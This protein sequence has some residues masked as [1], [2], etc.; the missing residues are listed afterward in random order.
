MPAEIRV[1]GALLD[2]MPEAALLGRA[3]TS[4][5][6]VAHE[7]SRLAVLARLRSGDFDAVVFPVVDGRG[8]P[9]APLI[10][11]CAT[12]HSRSAYIAICCSPP[13]RANAL[14][15]AARAGAQVVVAPSVSELTAL[16][17][18]RSHTVARHEV[19]TRRTLQGVEPRFLRDILAGATR[20]VGE[21]GRVRAFAASLDVST[22]TLSRQF[23]QAGL[24]SPRAVLA[25]AR[26]LLVC[27]M[28]ESYPDGEG[29][30]SVRLA[31]LADV[32]QLKRIARQ[33]A[34]PVG[35]GRPPTFPRFSVALDA[36]VKR[37]GGQ[38]NG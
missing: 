35:G 28:M 20:T 14:L 12:E 29:A 6:H 17:S 11:Q 8:L 10:Q 13:L 7:S 16:L 22:R 31:G 21:N 3:V 25:V 30:A 19:V 38:L 24:P 1:L 34:L 26:L 4:A 9:T 27:A 37:L 5:V 2:D 18:E 23:R 33:Y 32:R 15:A 36:V